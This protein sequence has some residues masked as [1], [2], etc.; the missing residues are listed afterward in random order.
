M[1]ERKYFNWPGRDQ[2]GEFA[3]YLFLFA[4]SI[5]CIVEASGYTPQ[6]RLIPLIVLVGLAVLVALKIVGILVPSIGA[7]I[8]VKGDLL[9][10]PDIDISEG[11]A[12]D[13]KPGKA[14]DKQDLRGLKRELVVIG[15]FLLSLVL[16]RL[17]GFVFAVPLFLF[18]FFLIYA[19]FGLFR[20]LIY[21][22][23]FYVFFYFVF[24]YILHTRFPVG[25]IF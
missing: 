20:S 9:A 12:A 25:L 19:R 16:I 8:D 13:D 24:I 15:W 1:C 2:L 7:R 5:Y 22:A 11:L 18:V 23:G 17:F 14:A 4:G 3:F 21:T 6:G 10:Q